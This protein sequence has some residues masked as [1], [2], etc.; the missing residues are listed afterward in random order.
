[1]AMVTDI[2]IGDDKQGQWPQD[3]STQTLKMMGNCILLGQ[4]L[5]NTSAIHP[6]DTFLH[7]LDNLILIYNRMWEFDF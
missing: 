4:D 3:L 2:F 5:V 7:L 6:D 1:M